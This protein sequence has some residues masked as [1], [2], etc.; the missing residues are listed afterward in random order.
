MSDEKKM[1]SCDQ[2]YGTSIGVEWETDIC[3]FDPTIKLKKLDKI[4][5]S[6]IENLKCKEEYKDGWTVSLETSISLPKCLFILEGQIGVS[7][8]MNDKKM[9]K[10]KLK[11]QIESFSKFWNQTIKDLKINIDG[12]DYPILLRDDDIYCNGIPEIKNINLKR[13]KPQITFGIKLEYIPL[14]FSFINHKFDNSIY[15]DI[16]IRFSFFKKSIIETHKFMVKENLDTSD[17]ELVGFLYLI[18]YIDSVIKY[19]LRYTSFIN[20]LKSKFVLKIR[21]NL[22]KLY[23]KKYQSIE[24]PKDILK[25]LKDLSDNQKTEIFEWDYPYKGNSNIFI[26]CRGVESFILLCDPSFYVKNILKITG[27]DILNPLF[28]KRYTKIEINDD[29]ILKDIPFILRV[30]YFYEYSFKDKPKEI[31]KELKNFRHISNDYLYS[32]CECVIDI[33][34]KILNIPGRH[35]HIDTP[36]WSFGK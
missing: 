21:T 5:L 15:Q 32:Y 17:H 24:L 1:D 27:E 36:Q 11:E 26:E 16:F 20:Y 6:C 4:P 28:Y 3:V 22:Y 10:E 33:L 25:V 19:E 34:D 14:L 8:S 9:N 2:N 23:K 12:I 18:F 29:D 13:G 30:K 35:I 7:C 31:I